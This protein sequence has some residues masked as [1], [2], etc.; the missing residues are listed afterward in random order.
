VWA[1]LG[2]TQMSSGRVVALPGGAVVE[3]DREVDAP[4]DVYAD[5][6]RFAT[7][8][9][10]VTEDGGLAI[11]IEQVLGAG[12]GTTPSPPPDPNTT[13]VAV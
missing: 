5:G 10:V 12:G 2:R 8:R 13:E 3:L 4:I 1:E 7:G 9:L 6:M 11:R